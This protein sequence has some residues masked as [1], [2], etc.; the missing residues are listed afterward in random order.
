[1]PSC[2]YNTDRDWIE[3]LRANSISDGVNFWRKDQR[4]FRL[5][6]GSP[7]YFK[8]RGTQQIAGRARFISQISMPV[9]KAWNTFGLGNGVESEAELLKRATEVLDINTGAEL[10]CLL[11]DGIELLPEENYIQLEQGEFPPSIMAGK[12]FQDEAIA[13][14]EERFRAYLPDQPPLVR[15][16]SSQVGELESQDAFRPSD[17]STAR[18]TTLRAI[19][20]RR[21]Q[22]GFRQRLINAYSGQCA[23]S[24]AA[25]L[26]VLEAAHIIPYRGEDTN[27]TQNGLLLR[28]DWHTLFDLGYWWIEDD[29][30]IGVSDVLKGS[31]YHGL[32]GHHLNL[33]DTQKD[34]PSVEAIQEH[35]A[36]TAKTT[37]ANKAVLPTANAVVDR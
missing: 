6:A 35:R 34:F 12:F 10:N 23:V 28:A 31:V 8:L 20:V 16:L 30:T 5:P 3:V 37:K 1:M 9:G 33:P 26:E 13:R 11:L 4:S 7:F 36:T 18:E 19:A 17:V 24:G 32:D 27:V 21:G 29:Y 14:I 15:D 2:V 22:S 25:P